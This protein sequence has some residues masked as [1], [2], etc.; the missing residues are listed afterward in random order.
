VLD[1][2]SDAT[3]VAIVDGL[4]LVYADADIVLDNTN[5]AVNFSGSW[6]T[7]SSAAGHFGPD[8]RFATASATATATA[9]FTPTFP[10][11]GLYDL[12]VWYPASSNRA[13]NAAWTISFFG[14]STNVLVNQQINGGGWFQLASARP[15]EAG[16]NG[17]V[18][19]SNL[20]SPVGNV[21]L[22]DAMKFSFVG[23]LVPVVVTGI[24]RRGDGN[25]NLSVSSTPGYGVWIDRT[26]NLISWTSV[27]NLLNASGATN[28]T[29]NFATNLNAGFYRARQ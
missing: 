15:F 7:A 24:A 12:F 10:N 11:S 5:S 25:I 2:F 9:I 16:T 29:D 14:G 20:A 28:F 13:T 19:L 3:N 22:A 18:S 17:F 1:N 4:K 26:T 23:P 8:Y 21:V 6:S 27:T